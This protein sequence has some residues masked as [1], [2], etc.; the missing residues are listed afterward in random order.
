M[1]SMHLLAGCLLAAV[2]AGPAFTADVKAEHW[3][4]EGKIIGKKD[5][6]A[7]DVSGFSCSTTAGFPRTCLIID[8]NIQAAQIITLEDGKLLAGAMVPLISNTFDGKALELD[9]EGVAFA[10]GAFYVIGSHGHPRDKDHELDPTNDAERIAAHI[11]AASQIAKVTINTGGKA[12]VETTL[13]LAKA[14]QGQPD[15]GDLAGKR[16]DE[17]GVTIEGIAIKDGQLFAGFRG[18]LLP[19]GHAAV[20][21]VSLEGLATGGDL[22]SKVFKLPLGEGIGIRDLAR[23]GDRILVLAGPGPDTAGAYTIFSWDGAGETVAS[24]VSL[25]DIPDAGDT[26]KAEVILPLADKKFLI[27]FDGEKEGSALAITLP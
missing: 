1:R 24:L 9:G 20:L 23:D 5:K 15:L 25:T 12:T 3:P 8:D 16:L 17:N 26:R 22:K 18:P 14:V 27:L 7:E 10:D 2:S 21:A 11:A 13:S 19:G 6:K 4:A